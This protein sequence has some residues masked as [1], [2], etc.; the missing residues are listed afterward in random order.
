MIRHFGVYR[1]ALLEKGEVLVGP[2]VMV[3]AATVFWFSLDDLADDLARLL[4]GEGRGCALSRRSARPLT[5]TMPRAHR[6]AS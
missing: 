3:D 1:G 6:R 2:G 5:S 4:D